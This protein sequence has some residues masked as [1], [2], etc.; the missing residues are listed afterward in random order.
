VANVGE[1]LQL[2]I[3]DLGHDGQGV[4]RHG[5]QVVFVS[6]AVPGDTVQVRLVAVARRHLIGQLQ[7]VMAPSPQ[8]RR[9]P[10]ILADHCGGCT[11]Q[12]LA[13]QARRSGSST[14]SSRPSSASVP[15]S[16]RCAP[17]WRP[18]P[19]WATATAP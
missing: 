7:R 16:P 10:C 6:G 3:T 1:K 13:D 14:P 19:P 4:G 11:L 2:E 18:I 9:P 8:R 17:C 15:S 5:G 12:P